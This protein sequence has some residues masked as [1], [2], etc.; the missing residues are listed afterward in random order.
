MKK[1]TYT[2][3]VLVLVLLGAAAL[4]VLRGKDDLPVETE[5]KNDE[6]ALTVQAEIKN[7]EDALPV[8]VEMKKGE[9]TVPVQARLK[10]GD[11]LLFEAGSKI[12]IEINPGF[13]IDAPI[14]A[15]QGL[16]IG[17]A[18]ADNSIDEPF[19]LF[20][21]ATQ[22]LSSAPVAVVDAD[23][24]STKLDFSSWSMTWRDVVISLGSGGSNE[25]GEGVAVVKCDSACSEGKS[26]TLDYSATIPAGTSPLS[27]LAYRLHMVG[28]IE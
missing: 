21:Q 22:H 12:S 20:E 6:D 4:L 28:T 10:N 25:S 14:Q 3:L 18:Q 7:G 2:K 16:V 17:E 13:W 9:D 15:N 11:T 8:Q 24:N 27:G 1:I 23:E 26:F 5:L 19:K